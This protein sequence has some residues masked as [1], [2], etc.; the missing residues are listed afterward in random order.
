MNLGKKT[1]VRFLLLLASGGL[2]FPMQALSL[3]NNPSV[4]YGDANINQS[5]NQMTITQTSNKTIINWE[6]YSIDVNELVQYIQ[7][8]KNSVSLN[9][10]T[11]GNPSEILGQLI[12]N[13]QIFLI[14]PSGIIFG[15][16]ARVNVAG[17]L[18]TTLNISDSDFIS[19]NYTFTQ[20]ANKALAAII[21]K[22]EIVI[23]DNGYAVL[24]APLV[25]NE[26]LIVANLGKVVIAGA[27]GF[28][29]NFD[30]QNL[31]NFA[32]TS[33][34]SGQPGTVLIPTSQVTN[35]IKE[36]VNTPQ[37]IEAG[38]IIE[39]DGNTYLV[40][41]SGTVINTGTIKVD[42]AE[43]KNA[44]T[45]IIDS[46]TATA[47]VPGSLLSAS[48][49]GADSSGGNIYILSEGNTALTPGV[50]ILA[51]GGEI[52][53]DGG[54]V[55]ASAGKSIYLGAKVDTTALNG[56]IGTYLIDPT[57]LYVADG[58][59]PGGDT[60][61]GGTYG[62]FLE[63]PIG[64][65]ADY[66]YETELEN[67]TSNIILQAA[68]NITVQN[69]VDDTISISNPGISITMQT[70]GTGVI[71]FVDVNDTLQTNNGAINISNPSGT[72]A[73][74]NL[75]TGGGTVGILAQSGTV[76]NIN[77]SST[78][79]SGGALTVTFT[80]TGTSTIGNIDT[81]S[82]NAGSSGG[83]I[84][85]TG[86]N[87]DITTGTI[88][89]VPGAG[90]TAGTVSIVAKTLDTG[91]IN[92]GGGDVT[93]SLS[94]TDSSFDGIST[95]G[96]NISITGGTNYTFDGQ[97][98]SGGGTILIT[99]NSGN[100]VLNNDISSSGGDITIAGGNSVVMDTGTGIDAGTGSLTI[101]AG[102][103]DITLE[104]LTTNGSDITITSTGGTLTFNND[105]A[106]SN[107]ELIVTGHNTITQSG[108]S[109]D[110][111]SGNITF[112]ADNDI[113][114]G[115][116]TTTGEAL[117]SSSSGSILE[118]GDLDADITANKVTLTAGTDISIDTAS[119]DIT[120]NAT[121]DITINNIGVSA[122]AVL[123][124][125]GTGDIEF[126]QQTSGD[127]DITATTNN[128]YISITNQGTNDIIATYVVAGND[129]PIYL[130]TDNGDVFVK[131]V[132][133]GGRVGIIS[134]G[135]VEEEPLSLDVDADIVADE[136]II[137]S[138]AGV[139][140]SDIIE[141]DAN[142]L[143]VADSSS[144][145]VYLTDTAGGLKIGTIGTYSGINTNNG[146]VNI[147]TSSPLIIDAPISAGDA[148]I[149]LTANNSDGYIE[150]NSS[151]TNTGAFDIT[152]TAN[153]VNGDGESI[154][155]SS[156][157]SI[158]AGQDAILTAS[159]GDSGDIIVS[160]ITAGRN[161]TITADNTGATP[162]GSILDDNDESTVL[163]AGT[164]GTV[165]LT[166]DVDIGANTG[167]GTIPEGYLDIDISN[168]PFL[169]I[170]TNT[171]NAYLRFIGSDLYS[172]YFLG[173]SVG[174]SEIGIAADGNDL[175]FDDG[176][177]TGLSQN[178]T[179]IANNIYLS[180]G[181]SGA[182]IGTT[183][184]VTL[185][186]VDG[187]IQDTDDTAGT[188]D[189][190]A[191]NLFME[192]TDGIEGNGGGGGWYIET[193]VNSL[194]A[195]VTSSSATGN[196]AVSNDKDIT[197]NGLTNYGSGYIDVY[198]DGSMTVDGNVITSGGDIYL[199]AENGLTI[200]ADIT[201]SDGY[202]YLDSDWSGDGTG[203]FVQNAGST[204]DAGS[205]T[206]DIYLSEASTLNDVRGDGVY[207][208]FDGDAS[209]VDN[210]TTSITAT[211]LVIDGG[212]YNLLSGGV[213]LSTAISYLQIGEFGSSSGDINIE[214][215]GGLTLT[216]MGSWGYS[217]ENTGGAVTISTSS[218]LTVDDGVYASGDI[219]LTAGGTGDDDLIVAAD[220]QSTSG[221]V[222][223]EANK[224]ILIN[225][226]TISAWVGGGYITLIADKNTD[227]TGKI[228]QT[229]GFIGSGVEALTAQAAEGISLGSSLSS[230][231][232]VSSI[233]ATDG[234]GFVG[235]YN[236]GYLTVKGI[237][238]TGNIEVKALSYGLGGNP[239]LTIAGDV[240][241]NGGQILMGA[242][243]DVYQNDA[244]TISSNGGLIAIE[245]DLDA[246]NDGVGSIV[247]NGSAII[248]SNGGDIYVFID[249][250]SS[251]GQNIQITGIDAGTGNVVVATSGGAIID[252][253]T[254]EDNDI[255]GN[256]L[257]LIATEGIGS[258]NAIETTVSYLDVL[259]DT[260][261]VNIANTGDL[262]LA[263][264]DNNI[265]P[266]Y[267]GSS[268]NVNGGNVN[269]SAASTITIDDAIQTNG[270]D[271][272]LTATTGIYQNANILTGGGGTGAG[273]Y[274]ADA[275][276]GVYTMAAGVEIDT[277]DVGGDG[278][279]DITAD[280]NITIVTIDA[281]TGTV[282]LTSD[283]ASILDDA[284]DVSAI[285][286]GAINLTAAVDI[287]ATDGQSG[288][289]P[290]FIDIDPTNLSSNSI[291][292]TGA[293][294]SNIYLNFL[295]DFESDFI[296]F[297][298]GVFP[299]NSTTSIASL[300]IGSSGDI[301]I[302]SNIFNVDD[303]GNP[304]GIYYDLY[305]LATNNLTLTNNIVTNDD[306]L[307]LATGGD[308]T[309]TM[310]NITFNNPDGTLILW[311]DFDGD[312]DGAISGGSS[313]SP[314]TL[315]NVANLIL[316]AA[317][318]IDIY[319]VADPI[320]IAAYNST[321]GEINIDNVG[322]ITVFDG[323]AY[324]GVPG[325]NV[326]GINNE[327]P[328]ED[329]NITAHSD[330]IINAPITTG[331]GDLTITA[332][333]NITHTVLGD[334]TTSGGTY[335]GNFD[336]DN[337]GSGAYTMADDGSDA[338]VIDV[339]VGN[340]YLVGGMLGSG[341]EGITISQ[342]IANTAVSSVY[343]LTSTGAISETI[344][345]TGGY[346]VTAN[347]LVM[348][349][350]DGISIDN[351]SISFLTAENSTNG[352]IVLTNTAP[353][354]GLT[355]S[356]STIPFLTGVVNNGGEVYIVENSPI[357]VNA[358]IFAT[359]DITLVANDSSGVDDGSITNNATI[360]SSGGEINLYA[361]T[362]VN[363]GAGIQAANAITIL[364][365]DST[366]A[367]NN[368]TG[369]GS[370]VNLGARIIAPYIYLS[371]V[372]IGTSATPISTDAGVLEAYA[373]SGDT[374]GGVYI[375]ELNQIDL[376]GISTYDGDIDINAGG[377]IDVSGNVDVGNGNT[378]YLTA[379]G[380]IVQAG[381]V[382][383][384]DSSTGNTTTLI[385]SAAGG[386]NLTTDITE[387]EATNTTSGN[388]EITNTGAGGG[389]YTMGSGVINNATGGN[390]KITSL[391]PVTID[392]PVTANGGNIEISS[393]NDFQ[394]RN[395]ISTTGSGT[396]TLT[397]TG[398]N[399]YIE[400]YNGVI[401]GSVQSGN[402]KIT[403]DA[404]Q[405]ITMASNTSIT[406]TTGDIELSAGGDIDVATITT[407][408][409]VTLNSGGAIT[410]TNGGANN[411][412]GLNLIALSGTGIDLDT[413][414]FALN[415]I[416]IGAGDINI[417]EAD[418]INLG[419]VTT[420]DGNI[421]I[422]TTDGTINVI[423]NGSA[424]GQITLTANGTGSDITINGQLTA[425]GDITLTAADL[426]TGSGL[427][428]G[429]LLTATAPNGISLNTDINTLTAST[430]DSNISIT[431][432]N[433][434]TLN[435][436]NA[437][438]GNVT[439]T[440][441]AGTL[442]S[443]TGTK[444]TGDELVVDGVGTVDINTNVNTLT[445][446]TNN[447]NITVKEDDGLA[448]N[449]VNAG[450]GDVDIEVALGAI[451][452]NNGGDLNIIGRDL[453]L[454]AETGIGSHNALET[455]VSN[456]SA[457]VTSGTATGGIEIINTGDLTLDDLAGWGYA[458]RNAGS[459]WITI[460]V[461]SNLT[462]DDPVI[463]TGGSITLTAN[464]GA[465]IQNA[466]GDITTSGGH[467][468][469]TAAGPYTMADGAIV[470]SGLG[471]IDIEVGGDITL[472][473]LISSATVYLESDGAILD[474]GDTGGED[475][476][477]TAV[478]F[479][480]ANGIGTL[481]DAIETYVGAMSA[482]TTNGQI[483]I[484][485]IGDLT[486]TGVGT[487]NGISVTNGGPIWLNTNG[488]SL[489]MLNAN[490]DIKSNGGPITILA[491]AV[492]QNNG[493]D[494]LSSG[495]NIE[496][497][498]ASLTQNSD[499]KID[500]GTGNVTIS[501][502]GNILLD[503]INGSTVDIRT[504]GG[505]IEE[506]SGD[507]G[508]DITGTNLILSASTGIGFTTLL[509]TQVTNLN[510]YNSTS[511]GI[512]IIN[513]GDLTI[514]NIAGITPISTP[515]Y[516]YAGR[517]GVYNNGGVVFIG[518]EDGSINIPGTNG[519]GVYAT[520]DIT[521]VASSDINAGSSGNDIAA[522]WS[523]HGYIDVEG[524]NIYLGQNGWADIIAYGNIYLLAD[525]NLRIDNDTWVRSGY[526][527]ITI[528]GDDSVNII[529]S[530]VFAEAGSIYVEGDY[531]NI[532]L[533]QIEGYDDTYI[534]ESGNI[535]ILDSEINAYYGQ[536]VIEA[537]DSVNIIN[538]DI[539]AGQYVRIYGSDGDVTIN[540]S[541]ITAENNYLDIYAY[542]NVNITDTSTYSFGN[543]TIEAETGNVL[544]DPSGIIPESE[545]ISDA[546]IEITAGNNITIIDSEVIAGNSA[547]LTAGNDI[548]I[549]YVEAG[550]TVSMEAGGSIYDNNQEG[551]NIV[552][553]D[554]VMLAG[555]GI[556]NYNG[557]IDPI[558][559]SVSNLQ[560]GAGDI[561][562][563][564]TGDLNLVDIN[565]LDFAVA[566][567]GDIEIKTT[568]DM[569]ISGLVEATG[570][571]YLYA[572]DGSI[573][574][575][576]DN[577]A[578]TPYDIMAGK[579]SG[580]YAGGGTIGIEPGAGWF[581]PIEVAID[582]DL[583]VYA[584]DEYNLVSV[585]IDGIVNPRDVLSTRSDWGVP[586]GLILFNGR[587]NGGGRSAQW[588]RAVSPNV[589]MIGNEQTFWSEIL[590]KVLD[591]SYIEAAPAFWEMD[592]QLQD[593]V[594]YITRK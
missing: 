408:G 496:M 585:A 581:D 451:T 122:T 545:I 170:T 537:D 591:S 491:G 559:T 140:V 396:I 317:E 290:G 576:L 338:S 142:T 258:A 75:V 255:T 1:V 463:S 313:G 316:I 406:S 573:I 109:I 332:T 96:G 266:A 544:I 341:G 184:N 154:I 308:L 336:S 272:T 548:Q 78:S 566:A 577:D 475:I 178:L 99:S 205:N 430:T 76:G 149:T 231:M 51:K 458:V 508:I 244:T 294:G 73:L 485:Q 343:L 150:V 347:H 209:I 433:G 538:S 561:Y 247:Q 497:N 131:Y 114:I 62:D 507:T 110:T 129:N 195:S 569:T 226:G 278:D 476:N 29:V 74:G 93:L 584:S 10:I 509:E 459:G 15:E 211:D 444:I 541:E 498:I 124:S 233:D 235:I 65:A 423:G 84:Q 63:P 241:S 282:S 210:G 21:N 417:E 465:I 368:S 480:A 539:Y 371:G 389:I 443:N 412:S 552:A 546:N 179:F 288:I 395:V 456:L 156:T 94:G 390:I 224:D 115:N 373:G 533:S 7:P 339:G 384:N 321:S 133:T 568:N 488:G 431:E 435:N 28:T 554:L 526:G 401:N 263:D 189:I 346:D 33:P 543:T 112:T 88:N 315:S 447:A 175:T 159:S 592:E 117:V 31:I 100:I 198:A 369:T 221:N 92:T 527:D 17:L 556:G 34:A 411:I 352:N 22:G 130:T 16:N 182:S 70:I 186:A 176:T 319:T 512:N 504:T 350:A 234:S 481:T 32:I 197:V 103:G 383:G 305:L 212:G 256:S 196:I 201:S 309:L 429:D 262:V 58:S 66:I 71:S 165:T 572:I 230:M 379:T 505:S 261:D 362:D 138:G 67:A 367:T 549:G 203:A 442:T 514:D 26:G 311:A 310:A 588:F 248:T 500:A 36:V 157:G 128:G 293:D 419:N 409:N 426:I 410:D 340:V 68:Q 91:D 515:P 299:N 376:A 25:S 237:T 254:T 511:G 579:T 2:L 525:S 49:V 260:G 365:D 567:Y 301:I 457:R 399:G 45:I 118:D 432:A 462:I 473:Q 190:I 351:T 218:P 227:S 437:G 132:E 105:I 18:A 300:T 246:D 418:A 416:V 422:T 35:I 454:S 228:L 534:W 529:G 275:G 374:T 89:T 516:N 424:D 48:G 38:Q 448:L 521:L 152:L 240:S 506:N 120:A 83:N 183:G 354:G 193:S 551:M 43:G 229:G 327:A 522:A 562:I 8:G 214:N 587:M 236:D 56:N 345:E 398:A 61:T 344:S 518:V 586:P 297:P 101:S 370:I 6:G 400:L 557:Q 366:V 252:N 269:I 428:S 550:N 455:Q 565:S 413:S 478:E 531:V 335:T 357:I 434:L 264:T 486:I 12:S 528:E 582:G 331:G 59:R 215:T 284:N 69:I 161:I 286:A 575:N 391:N 173:L 64:S 375:T 397:A 530:W 168:A 249:S 472:G 37:L 277:T 174:G 116:I 542:N 13:G 60:Y 323:S 207:I 440:L 107:G 446:S 24:V 163:Q 276:T 41:A 555:E 466:T 405:R 593:S 155:M 185:T 199:T 242:E 82:T 125:T 108:G 9:R 287:G 403:L 349:A 232:S 47:L 547:Y 14:N 519:H 303:N 271:L 356:T 20:D 499:S 188:A 467:Y 329:V 4:I 279:V 148:N 145:G 492:T 86:S 30:G 98:L 113:T 167:T 517:W 77:T 583:N 3:P 328:F 223:L 206:V 219:T 421:D 141:I 501:A 192:A 53:G 81:S 135:A 441:L 216:D 436:V 324:V 306:I 380:G 283:N 386:I 348:A 19:G 407:S 464:S 119:S 57:T 250:P 563:G 23:T 415:A 50:T 243:G 482:V 489:T 578:A 104:S 187:V 377:T 123:D 470:N 382:V 143:V 590:L 536:L 503:E 11:G 320:N 27:E 580:L 523:S 121:G 160:S 450:L 427:V 164:A 487:T 535:N 267:D 495:G 445:S 453:I 322:D 245:A 225:N 40:G 564:N 239:I 127:I 172:V 477:A 95:S 85:I 493:A 136:L 111:G 468:M 90:G 259:N 494:I 394:I 177:F 439:L 378:I 253:D 594:D 171:G 474:G 296:V 359:G 513:T 532:L 404:D 222:T 295:G 469:A 483:Y 180:N 144:N 460:T 46:N 490:Q 139:G 540:A 524:G 304:V 273:D 558:E 72:V 44:G 55:E 52:S 87:V 238:N 251:T 312:E 80:G 181:A 302:N 363:I 560:A 334:I 392:Q 54:F 213:N 268:V 484:N 97:L 146:E 326:N 438:T 388:I 147:S 502:T 360:T 314:I 200:N 220:V 325:I 425:T 353:D 337:N 126:T 358:P 291:T 471:I 589:V 270:G 289:R 151:I 553:T 574:D 166:A 202:I 452:D 570:S 191:N 5:G 265:L 449:L 137:L 387:I 217:I 208:G 479:I 342:I 333:G 461:N 257:V 414:V 385:L 330:V 204:I 364:A 307:Q 134:A 318:G 285:T 510:A 169:S 106:T 420:S 153:G 79:A 102:S 194:F 280:D 42:G 162:L 355:I 393:V 571:V 39:E 298:T 281:G 274:T 381:G 402:G 158:T 292:L 361:G 372:D 520:G